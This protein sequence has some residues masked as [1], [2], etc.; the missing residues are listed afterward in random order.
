MAPK[1]KSETPEVASKVTTPVAEGLHI[2]ETLGNILSE[3]IEKEQMKQPAPKVAAV[4][5][6][7][8]VT[9]K[10]ALL[11]S[12]ATKSSTVSWENNGTHGI[13][14]DMLVSLRMTVKEYNGLREILTALRGEFQKT[15]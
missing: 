13:D 11:G 10:V 7:A 14:G 15:I 12:L 6:D 4:T 5:E 9:R 2:A 1:P 3:E 8:E